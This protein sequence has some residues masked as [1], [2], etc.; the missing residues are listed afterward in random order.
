MPFGVN[1]IVASQL[2]QH[3]L[4][5][6]VYRYTRCYR[7]ERGTRDAQAGRGRCASRTQP[8]AGRARRVFTARRFFGAAL[9]VAATSAGAARAADVSAS[10]D[11]TLRVGHV[12]GLVAGALNQSGVGV[13][14]TLAI[15]GGATSTAGVYWVTGKVRG[16]RLTVLGTSQAGVRIRW[17]AVL[18]GT[19]DIT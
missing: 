4:D 14:G 3:L 1:G 9:L 13:M 10:Y 18:R 7:M 16:A 12:T 19:D 11:G 6:G 5:T 15:D 2:R 17:R 8:D